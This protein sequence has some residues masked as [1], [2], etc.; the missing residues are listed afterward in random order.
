MDMEPKNFKEP[1]EKIAEE[2]PRLREVKD[3]SPQLPAQKNTSRS[4]ADTLR[5][6]K[7]R[8]LPP[9]DAPPRTLLPRRLAAHAIDACV[10]ALI[11][12]GIYLLV[13]ISQDLN[14][15]RSLAS[16]LA[17][18]TGLSSDF[19]SGFFT[20]DAVFSGLL[21]I[22]LLSL[23]NAV[24]PG[25]ISILAFFALLAS[26]GDFSVDDLS[27][28][29]YL[30][31]QIVFLLC[32]LT[33]NVVLQK[34]FHT[35]IGKWLMGLGLNLY[36]EDGGRLKS[37]PGWLNLMAREVLRM[38]YID[39]VVPWW[40]P[41][42]FA[43]KW[44]RAERML[45]DRLALTGV[46]EEVVDKE[47]GQSAFY[48]K[49]AGLV[50]FTAGGAMLSLIYLGVLQEPVHLALNKIY[51]KVAKF[52]DPKLYTEGLIRS[53]IYHDQSYYQNKG[54]LTAISGDIDQITRVLSVMKSR[55]VD[56][57]RRCRLNLALAL[58]YETRALSRS[59]E[60][61]SKSDNLAAAA[62]FETYVEIKDR[63]GLPVEDKTLNLDKDWHVPSVLYQ[64]SELYLRLE[65]Y[66]DAVKIAERALTSSDTKDSV[67]PFIYYVEVRAYEKLDDKAKMITTLERLRDLYKQE[68]E[69][70]LG[71]K[72]GR[73]VVP[74][75]Q[76]L[77]QTRLRLTKLYM[78]QNRRLDARKEVEAARSLHIKMADELG[79]SFKVYSKELDEFL[80]R[81]KAG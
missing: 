75:Y 25:C 14:S 2:A 67:K 58:L 55:Q 74:V 54:D 28:R 34:K 64:M 12:T 5:L 3:E 30:F 49:R 11:C 73:Q 45:Y 19:A 35:T 32:P 56:E 52:A 31:V 9:V 59:S 22:F 24:F 26:A 7:S 70:A 61:L 65:R 16:V 72:G 39:F 68:L 47:P 76:D 20:I 51:L 69:T 43:F 29:H 10:I 63:N 17:Y 50:L 40:Y 21:A 78:E 48:R 46:V 13:G 53:I 6:T 80:S 60:S 33:Y 8:I 36:G 44:K 42:S 1:S 57:R 71:S 37:E 27:P 4:L 79:E 15:R 41:L 66:E 38:L 62:N 77:F 81:L 18:F 23:L